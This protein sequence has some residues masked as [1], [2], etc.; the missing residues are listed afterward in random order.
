MTWE[1]QDGKNGLHECVE[2]LKTRQL[3]TTGRRTRHEIAAWVGRESCKPSRRTHTAGVS[4]T[5][6]V[7][8]SGKSAYWR[9]WPCCSSKSALDLCQMARWESLISPK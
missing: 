6:G 8:S 7:R 3:T 1:T 4:L 5:V 9:A 2:S